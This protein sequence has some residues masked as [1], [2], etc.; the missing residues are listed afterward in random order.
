IISIKTNTI[1]KMCDMAA[2]GAVTCCYGVSCFGSV[3]KK[4][5]GTRM[6]YVINFMIVSILSYLFSSYAYSWFKNI[7]VFKVCSHDDECYG[8]LVVYRLTFALAVYHILL[9]LVLIGVKSSENGR[10]SI[11][12][13]YWPLKLLFLAGF[14]VVTF[15]IP[16]SFFKYY[17]WVSLVGAAI[18]ILIQL[19]LLIEFAY[20]ISENWIQKV[21]DEG[22]VTKKWYILLLISS[23]GTV[24]LSLAL[25]ITMLVLWS[26]TSSLNQFFIIFNMGIS[27]IIGLLSITEKSINHY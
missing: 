16:N 13:G 22:H 11:Q 27:L 1:T 6:L 15:F 14:T 21:E 4:S 12:D 23:I 18:F 25:S 3:I 26:K 20:S 10:A 17:A 24:A 5:T 2:C 8:S 9:G 7:D 19:V